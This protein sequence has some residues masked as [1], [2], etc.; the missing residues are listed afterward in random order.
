MLG[1]EPGLVAGKANAGAS[2]W[3]LLEIPTLAQL[4]LPEQM[5][6]GSEEQDYRQGHPASS[7]SEKMKWG[8]GDPS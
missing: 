4:C 7:N 3:P 8:Q 6:P 1:I 5:C 2:L